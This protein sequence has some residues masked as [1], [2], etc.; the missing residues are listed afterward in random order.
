MHGTVC[1]SPPSLPV[2]FWCM[3][4]MRKAADQRMREAQMTQGEAARALRDE[5]AAFEMKEAQWQVG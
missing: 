4:E 5:R 2:Y 1:L 3:Q